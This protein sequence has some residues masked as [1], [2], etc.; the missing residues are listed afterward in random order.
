MTGN[1]PTR[2]T[3]AA[4]EFNVGTATIIEFLAKKGHILEDNPNTKISA[5]LYDLLVEEFKKDKEAKLDAK[6]INIG[7]HRMNQTITIDDKPRKQEDDEIEWQNSEEGTHLVIRDTSL[8]KDSVA[9]KLQKQRVETEKKPDIAIEIPKPKVLGSIDLE[10]IETE[11]KPKKKTVAKKKETEVKKEETAQEQIALEGEFVITKEEPTQKKE[12]V[13]VVEHQIEKQQDENPEIKL[14]T[15][16]VSVK[17]V[18]EIDL[19]ALDTKTKPAK[20]SAEE[21][22]REREER[23][24]K[25]KEAKERKKIEK[26][27]HIVEEPVAILSEP[28]ESVITDTKA[29]EETDQKVQNKD[30]VI[31]VK[32][33]KIEAPTILGTIDLSQFERKKKPVASSSEDSTKP[34]KSGR[35]KRK[36][37]KSEKP[38][39][40]QE[41]K[42]A[43]GTQRQEQKQQQQAAATHKKDLHKKKNKKEII[44]QEPTEEEIQKQ[45]RDTLSKLTATTKSKGSK[46][47]REKREGIREKLADEARKIEAEKNILKVTEFVTANEL[48]TMMNVSV[49]QVISVC[50]TVGVFVSINQRLDA[51]TIVF[52]ADEFGFKVSF[53]GLEDQDT[54]QEEDIDKPEDLLPRHPIVT[55]MGHVDHGKTKLL[56]YIR[57]ANVVAGEAGGITQ[58]IGAYSVTLDDGRKITFLDTPGHE[59]FTAMR[60]RGAKLTDVA[61]IVIAADDNVMP[62]T[63]E[64]INHA[65]AANVPIVFA[66]NKIDKPTA[67]PD[68]IRQELAEMN[69]LVEEWGGKYQCQEIS[70]KQGINVDLLLEKVLLEAEMLELKANPNR[71]AKGTVIESKLEP[72]RGYVASMLIQNGTLHKGDV[73]V[74]GQYFGRIKALFNE[75]EQLIDEV[76]PATP[77]LVLGLNGAP[78]AGDVFSVMAE[79]REARNLA[80]KRQQLQ[81]EI[82]LRTQKHIT[83]DDIGRSIAMGSFKELNIIVKGDVDGSVEALSDSLLKLSSDEVKVN[84]IHKSVGAIIESDV[85]LA[86]ASD[87]VIIGFQVRP[88]VNARKLAESEQID[89][90]IYS[91]IYQA[92]EEIKAAIEGM[93]APEIKEEITCNV[94]VREIFKINKVGTIAGCL[95]LDGII[96]RDVKVRVIRDGIVIYGGTLGSLKRYKDDVKEVRSG[97]EC[98]LNINN[99]NDIKVGDII[100]GYK[101]IEI[102]RSLK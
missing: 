91:I 42:T 56:D 35:K 39:A 81:R 99:F 94:E 72:G 82:G 36:R 86:S 11:S 29:K 75:R 19:D 93:L 54:V 16:K 101:E 12:E 68:R 9:G 78:Q 44:K 80:T 60:A 49:N 100:E 50:M 3:K 63:K 96:T 83:L 95:V 58:H 33:D 79:E 98:G 59:A 73:I 64:A 20:K 57:H 74:A 90:R 71:L 88:T 8:S 14:T 66:I 37:I 27:Q 5:E 102:K 17:I 32:V 15:P 48:A 7:V 4:R 84:V 24:L 31:R 92:I 89:I 53:I 26:Q 28:V 13:P 61:I 45:I 1:S 6:K 46:H 51:E 77:A 25:E 69:I 23:K 67:D 43:H 52:I 18:G 34:N 10:K 87:A 62:Q 70:A 2:L 40:N 47:R 21:K 55:V 97:M 76:L 38:A 30:E 65:Q 41:K 85:L 22:K